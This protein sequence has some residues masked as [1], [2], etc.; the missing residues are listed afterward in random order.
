[1]MTIEEIRA[2]Q[3]S[4]EH[5]EPQNKS[6][7][8]RIND[9]YSNIGLTL[10]LIVFMASFGLIF[11]FITYTIIGFKMMCKKIGNSIRKKDEIIRG[12]CETSEQNLLKGGSEN[13]HS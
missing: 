3:T 7:S 4:Q 13:E 1:M 2:M 12:S 10:G 11:G 8:S 5:L 6:F 9:F